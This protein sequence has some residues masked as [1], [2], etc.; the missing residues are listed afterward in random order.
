[1]SLQRNVQQ[2]IQAVFEEMLK[3]ARFF[4]KNGVPQGIEKFLLAKDIK[5]EESIFLNVETQG[6]MLGLEHGFSGF[7]VTKNHSVF[8]AEFELDSTGNILEIIH[9]EDVTEIQNFS[10]YNK[11]TGHGWGAI[12]ID[13]LER[14]NAKTQPIGQPDG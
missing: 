7:I 14:L 10:K 8:D 6:F 5:T 1:M 3:V 11:G 13:V 4:R 12:A 9:F 2:Q